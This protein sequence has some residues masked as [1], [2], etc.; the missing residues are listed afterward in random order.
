MQKTEETKK[1]LGKMLFWM[2]D[3][4]AAPIPSLV[5]I[6]PRRSMF[7]IAIEGLLEQWRAD[8]GWERRAPRNDFVH[9]L[10]ATLGSVISNAGTCEKYEPER[11]C[12][13]ESIIAHDS[14]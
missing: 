11:Q 4:K 7:R 14:A 10:R 13:S 9:D 2:N 1:N 12:I 3:T 6:V 5:R 8:K